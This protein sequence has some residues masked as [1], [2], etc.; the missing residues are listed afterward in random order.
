MAPIVLEGVTKVF[1]DGT[2]AVREVDLTVA[3]GEFMVLVGPSGC[4]KSTLLRMIAGLEQTTEGRILIGD[5]DVTQRRT[6]G[7][8]RRDGVPE[9]R[10]LP[11]HVGA[12]QPRLLAQGRGHPEGRAARAGRRAWRPCSD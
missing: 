8:R 12:R 1:P 7:P 6:A 2:T 10:A 11:A 4:G 9:L 5:R 3:S